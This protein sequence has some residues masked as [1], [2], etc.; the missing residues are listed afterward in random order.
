LA[1]FKTIHQADIFNLRVKQKIQED[2]EKIET[3]D[4]NMDLLNRK[5]E[6][7]S[8]TIVSTIQ[9]QHQATNQQLKN[10]LYDQVEK[11]IAEHPEME[12]RRQDLYKEADVLIKE[13][14][15]KN[16]SAFQL[17]KKKD[18]PSASQ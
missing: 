9:K 5:L 6:D 11:F 15:S 8:T 7:Y 12:S 14:I 18:P 3:F 13:G 4:K 1:I 16:S 10:S 17:L 2:M